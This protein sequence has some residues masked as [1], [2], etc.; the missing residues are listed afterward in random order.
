MRQ[1]H[2]LL[3]RALRLPEAWAPQR[4][5][6]LGSSPLSELLSGGETCGTYLDATG[7][8]TLELTCCDSV[9]RARRVLGR[10]A[11]AHV[12]GVRYDGAGEHG[13]GDGDG[14]GG[15]DGE[16]GAGCGGGAAK[17]GRVGGMATRGIGA[18]L[19]DG[20]NLSAAVAERVGL[21]LRA[22]APAP[23]LL[24]QGEGGGG[25]SGSGGSS[26]AAAQPGG[27]SEER[28]A[29]SGAKKPFVSWAA[30]DAAAAAATPVT[31]EQEQQEQ[32]EQQEEEGAAAGVGPLGVRFAKEI[33]LGLGDAGWR[34]AASQLAAAG[35]TQPLAAVWRLPGGC[36]TAVRVA[37]S[38]GCALVLQVA[39]VD[40]CRVALARAG[41]LGGNI[42][43]T[44]RGNRG[45]LFLGRGGG[46]GAAAADAGAGAGAEA[47][48]IDGIGGTDGFDG[49]DAGAA[50]GALAGL[51]VR[52][53]EAGG[54]SAAFHEAHDT[55]VAADPHRFVA[56]LQGDTGSGGGV[57]DRGAS[58]EA[59]RVAAARERS[60]K[61]DCWVEARVIMS[62]PARVFAEKKS[63]PKIWKGF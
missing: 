42:G 45:Q 35:A 47:V 34:S 33:K 40:A 22:E 18:W 14:G 44:G 25:V 59:A 24:L 5:G 29:D 28:A 63:A 54:L 56:E 23:R 4:V 27:S 9:A 32:Q 8:V 10:P 50:F 15:G 7:R 41:L 60:A 55:V 19:S 57:W 2:S 43:Q 20:A 21:V 36:P 38:A 37:P 3:T 49:F 53:C 30:A 39:D 1:A 51:E 12:L 52:L 61:G 26:S 17:Q 46:G 62:K 6:G 11:R 48:G 16:A 13:G 58:G 31:A